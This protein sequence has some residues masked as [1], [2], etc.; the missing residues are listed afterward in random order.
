MHIYICV[1]FFSALLKNIIS[2]F[3]ILTLSRV[4]LVVSCCRVYQTFLRMV[5]H[6]V[7]NLC[8][9]C[10]DATRVLPEHFRPDSVHSVYINHP[11]PPLQTG[12]VIAREAKDTVREDGEQA[13][14]RSRDWSEGKHLLTLV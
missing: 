13:E 9:I 10:G 3:Y 5:L 11:E 8:A 14:G 4:C 6:E 2:T 12:R 1:P 7:P